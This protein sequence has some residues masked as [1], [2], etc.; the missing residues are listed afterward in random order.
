MSGIVDIRGDCLWLK[1]T[2][3]YDAALGSTLE[4]VPMAASFVREEIERCS[5]MRYLNIAEWP[6]RQHSRLED[7]QPFR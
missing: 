6:R 1:A 7:R 5:G 3:V 2:W 4:R